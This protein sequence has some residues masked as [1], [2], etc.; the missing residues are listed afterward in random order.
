MLIPS[1]KSLTNVI[2]EC[3]E[4]FNWAMHVN[5]TREKTCLG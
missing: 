2:R 1:V 4:R 3:S 5:C